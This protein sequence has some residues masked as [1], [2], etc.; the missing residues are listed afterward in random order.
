MS[1]RAIIT[2]RAVELWTKDL[3]SLQMIA[4]VFGV[5]RQAVKKCLN[6][7]GIDTGYRRHWVSCTYCGKRFIKA[8]AYIRK[9]RRN[10]CCHEHY[11][12]AIHN[13]EYYECR[14]GQKNAKKAVMACGYHVDYD[15]G[16][17]CHHEDGDTTNNDPGN[18]LVFR[19]HA[20]HM[21]WH[22]AGGVESGVVPVWPLAHGG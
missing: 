13:P 14:Q 6:K 15:I 21:R 7:Q 19:D 11:W 8:R 22:R 3:Y 17:V 10:Y 5:C 2:G 20:D 18:L 1:R 16:E 4:N 12:A 9:T